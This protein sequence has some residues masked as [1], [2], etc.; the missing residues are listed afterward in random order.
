M[1]RRKLLQTLAASAAVAGCGG[2]GTD[3]AT[4]PTPTSAGECTETGAQGSGPFYLAVDETSVDITDG[5][6]G[7][8]LSLQLQIVDADSCAGIAGA[9]VEVWQA[10]AEGTYSGFE[11]EGTVGETFLRGLLLTDEL[12]D[13]QI[14]TIVPGFYM[15]RTLH[16][17]MR[18]VAE[19]YPELVTQLYFPKDTILAVAPEYPGIEEY[20]TNIEDG[21]YDAANELTIT[22]DNGGYVASF[23]V[24]L[25]A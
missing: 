20:T 1:N 3:S 14:E 7:I 8:P 19:G 12:G 4:S 5:K 24:G 18:I 17:H 11:E 6:T 23:V 15:N 13:C 2:K 16:I 10:D 21:G 25:Q 22:G 9:A